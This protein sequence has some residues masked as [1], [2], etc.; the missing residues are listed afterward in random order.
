MQLKHNIIIVSIKAIEIEGIKII[1]YESSL[2]YVNVE[3]FVYKIFKLSGVNPNNYIE[4]MNKKKDEFAKLQ[5][6]FV[7]K[8]NVVEPF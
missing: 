7:K 8:N 1:R 6:K 4:R 3:N 2:F 5:R